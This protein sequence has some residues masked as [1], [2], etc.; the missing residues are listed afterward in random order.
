MDGVLG[1]V[2]LGPEP[3]E[4]L[5]GGG[6]APEAAPVS[7]NG[8]GAAPEPVLDSTAGFSAPIS[9]GSGPTST[10]AAMQAVAL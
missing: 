4:Q 1:R 3:G 5:G 2:L 9:S 6:R 7:G 8:P 10:K